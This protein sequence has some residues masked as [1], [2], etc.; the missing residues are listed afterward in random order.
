M[1]EQSFEK[2]PGSNPGDLTET[3]TP[4]TG[5]RGGL[6]E[7]TKTLTEKEQTAEDERKLPTLLPDGIQLSEFKRQDWVV[8]VGLDVRESDIVD[9][10]FWTHVCG[11]FKQLDKIEVRWEDGHKIHNLRVLWCDK[12]YANV[13]LISVEK[14]GKIIPDESMSSSKFEAVWKGELGYCVIRKSDRQ[15]VQTHLRNK[16]TAAAW[17][18]DNR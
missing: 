17:I 4:V 5:E 14:L 18:S 9:S 7:A 8:Q 1:S 16:E 13:K 2:Y 15:M 6:P 10:A 12:T 11:Q 3:H